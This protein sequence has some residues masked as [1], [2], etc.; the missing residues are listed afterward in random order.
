M[1]KTLYVKLVVEGVPEVQFDRDVYGKFNM[2]WRKHRD[3]VDFE[4][5]SITGLPNDIFK[6]AIVDDSKINV[7]NKMTTGIYPYTITVRYRDPDN[8]A[9]KEATSDIHEPIAEGGK[10]VI[11]N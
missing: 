2:K 10:P 5:V 1:S 8:H 11:R 7:A 4:F 3:S 6:I 9:W